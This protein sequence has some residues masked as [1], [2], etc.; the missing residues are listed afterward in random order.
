M[1]NT[2][3]FQ[4][5]G[6]DYPKQITSNDFENI[7]ETFKISL[8]DRPDLKRWFDDLVSSFVNWMHED[9]KQPNRG[10][11]HDRI[12][13]ALWYIRKAAADIDRLGPS[14]C[15]A[16]PHPVMTVRNALKEIDSELLRALRALDRQRGARGGPKRKIY[17]DYLVINLAVKWTDL[18]KE[19]LIGPRSEFVEFCESAAEAIGWPTKG[20]SEAVRLRNFSDAELLGLKLEV[21][22]RNSR[23]RRNP[24]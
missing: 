3:R 5:V 8:S 14:G 19:I 11:D 10:D 6:F 24:P 20:I 9:R 23:R 7:C 22:S 16:L 13:N 17:R 15:T 1:L 2:E 21:V 18:G 4:A 12:K